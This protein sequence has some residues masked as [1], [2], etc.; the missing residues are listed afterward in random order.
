LWFSFRSCYKSKPT[1]EDFFVA[2]AEK[3]YKKVQEYLENG[4]Q[5]TDDPNPIA[6][7]NNDTD[8]IVLLLQ[9]GSNPNVVYQGDSLL[10]WS[11][12]EN[13]EVIKGRIL[14]EVRK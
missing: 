2:V 5:L 1:D 11:V 3:N 9:N 13:K 14:F 7:N 10:Y 12:K 4:Y 8:M 6:I